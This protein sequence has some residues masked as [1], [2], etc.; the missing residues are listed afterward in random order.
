MLVLRIAVY[1]AV[2][3]IGVGIVAYLVSHD[4]RWLRFA[5]QVGKYALLLALLIFALLAF[6][7]LFVAV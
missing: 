4:R 2:V 7:R 3:A 6:E 1:A 5:W